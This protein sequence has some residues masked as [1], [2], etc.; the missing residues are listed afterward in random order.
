MTNLLFGFS[1]LWLSGYG[2]LR[3]KAMFKNNTIKDIQTSNSKGLLSTISIA[4]VL[5]FANPH[6]YLDTMLLIGSVSQQFIGVNKTAF[7]L[8]ASIASFI[9]FFS[10]AY[11]AKLL[12]PLMNHPSSWRVLDGFTAIIMFSIAIKLANTGNWL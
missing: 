1:A 7:A 10:L 6:V 11:S 8:G 3:L 4:A 12:T 5:T 9:F 2:L